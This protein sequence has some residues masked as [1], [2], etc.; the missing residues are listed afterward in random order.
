LADAVGG[1]LVLLGNLV[2]DLLELRHV[3]LAAF[4]LALLLLTIQFLLVWHAF[5]IPRR[6][7]LESPRGRGGTG[8]RDGFRTRW[9]KALG[10]SSPLA[11]K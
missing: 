2:G 7:I 3:A 1:F 6:S 10:G 11:R 4:P 9:A 8:I 5:V